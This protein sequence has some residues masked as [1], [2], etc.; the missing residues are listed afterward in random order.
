MRFL[1]SILGRLI[2]STLIA[3]PFLWL[4]RVLNISPMGPYVMMLAVVATA[5]P[6]TLYQKLPRLSPAVWRILLFVALAGI[7]LL[8]QGFVGWIT[9]LF[10]ITLLLL[11]AL[12]FI[13]AQPGAAANLGLAT[14][15]LLFALFI[16]NLGAG[17]VLA[18]L[19]QARA[20][21]P[22]PEP[23]PPATP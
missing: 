8:T 18:Q 23:A 19:E 11:L 3:Y 16:A 6:I 1:S 10:L 20:T 13:Y 17:I 5:V 15:G 7:G 4:N 12:S 9:A 2:F 14:F 22:P 21:P